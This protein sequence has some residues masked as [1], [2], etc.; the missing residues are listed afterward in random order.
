[1]SKARE[2]LNTLVEGS[3]KKWDGIPSSDLV[4]ILNDVDKRI[5]TIKAYLKDPRTKDSEKLKKIE[6][7]ILELSKALS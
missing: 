1:M 7:L 6:S 4:E 2:L 5:Y 3:N